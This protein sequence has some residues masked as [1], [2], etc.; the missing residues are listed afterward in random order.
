MSTRQLKKLI[1]IV[2]ATIMTVA[3]HMALHSSSAPNDN[4]E[5]KKTSAESQNVNKVESKGGKGNEDIQKK[6]ELFESRFPKQTPPGF[7]ERVWGVYKSVLKK[8]WLNINDIDYYCVVLN[9]FQEPV[10]AAE[11]FFCISQISEDVS[12]MLETK[13][14]C[15]RIKKQITISSDDQ[16]IS[17][18]TGERGDRFEITNITKIGYSYLP[19][20]KSYSFEIGRKRP[21]SSL[22]EPVKVYLID[23]K[24]SEP[25]Y[26]RSFYKSINYN[27]LW[28]VDVL[29]KNKKGPTP[30]QV[31]L[32][33]T[34]RQLKEYYKTR[35]WEL[36]LDPPS[37]IEI[38]LSSKNSFLAEG[39]SSNKLVV[40]NEDIDYKGHFY[41]FF[42][43]TANDF[44]SKIKVEVNG[45]RSNARVNLTSFSNPIKGSKNLTYVKSK[46]LKT[47]PGVIEPDKK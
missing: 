47:W 13:R 35:D 1:L 31:N 24:L 22:D 20:N 41:I 18:L 26:K 25:L 9:Q 34:C 17:H 36:T 4:T 7:P 43:D 15:P 2:V 37:G 16:G 38:S 8:S 42:H 30:S 19:A 27:E 23:N 28:E 3:L 46:E 21:K 5:D 10:E 45:F 12:K 33:I 44:Y 32:L 40:K 11:V 14:L 39:L 6:T 29:R